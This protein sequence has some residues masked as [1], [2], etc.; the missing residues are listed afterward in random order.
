[1]SPLAP[2]TKAA[3]AQKAATAQN[4]VAAE[5][6][7]IELT[8]AASEAAPIVRR[9]PDRKFIYTISDL[10]GMRHDQS[11]AP[12]LGNRN[13]LA[14]VSKAP[15]SPNNFSSLFSFNIMSATLDQIQTDRRM[16]R[17]AQR[18][19]NSGQNGFNGDRHRQM[20]RGK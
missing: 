17:Q 5:P 14:S 11:R 20:N 19:H 10:F 6:Q 7:I 18:Y 16:H 9:N 2:Q 8:P 15:I 1:M 3:L 4:G 12:N 13:V